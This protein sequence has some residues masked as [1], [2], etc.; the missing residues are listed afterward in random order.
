MVDVRVADDVL[1]AQPNPVAELPGALSGWLGPVRFVIAP[2]AHMGDN[3]LQNLATA[4]QAA[5]N[6][7]WQVTAYGVELPGPWAASDDDVPTEVFGPLLFQN[8]LVVGASAED[9]ITPAQGATML[10][11][12]LGELHSRNVNADVSCP[13]AG[14]N[15]W[16]LPAWP[17]VQGSGVDSAQVLDDSEKRWFVVRTVRT[18]TTTGVGYHELEWLQPDRSWSRDAAYPIGLENTPGGR[19][20]AVELVTR[21]REQ[22]SATN[23]DPHLGEVNSV[24]LFPE[25]RLLFHSLP[26]DWIRDYGH[27]WREPAAE[28]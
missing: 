28:G 15:H 5:A 13:P 24:L 7:F 9:P 8:G 12:M 14:L 17:D 26:P 19:A 23:G 6:R 2:P 22:A 1:A 21:L 4:A 10:R 11:I 27:T 3:D 25:K 16:T 20:A 18:V